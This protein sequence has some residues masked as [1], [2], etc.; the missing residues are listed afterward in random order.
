M[1]EIQSIQLKMLQELDHIC[2]KHYINYYLAYGSCLG[3]V[4]EKGFIPWDHDI[5]VA[6]RI[7][8]AKKLLE[9]KDEFTSPYFL[10]SRFN[11]KRNTSIKYLI[12]DSSKECNL[13]RGT[14]IV[15]DN[16]RIGLDILPLYACP[17]SKMALKMNV[18]RS[19]ILKILLGGVPKNHGTVY[20]LIG[21][22]ILYLYGGKSKNKTICAIERKLEYKGKHDKL[23]DYFGNSVSLFSTVTFDVDWFGNPSEL[24]FE[25]LRFSGP[26]NPDSYLKTLYGDY[27]TPPPLSARKN[28]TKLIIKTNISR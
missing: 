24:M 13:V 5:D 10:S 28:E 21:N 7:E 17:T 20:K 23:A 3:A 6:M 1:N 22:I 18:V 11:D 26:T 25:G 4:R 16:A 12:V 14:T 8:D 27:M 2:K 9:Y 15:D 19:H